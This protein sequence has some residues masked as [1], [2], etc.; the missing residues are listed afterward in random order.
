M[1]LVLRK[2]GKRCKCF[3]CGDF[4]EDEEQRIRLTVQ[5]TKR[6]THLKCAFQF[7]T[8]I[9]RLPKVV[10]VADDTPF[11]EL[12]PTDFVEVKKCE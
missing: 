8:F 12:E 4:I 9:L 10:C 11:S 5:T 2:T 1:K 6:R 3:L 7:S